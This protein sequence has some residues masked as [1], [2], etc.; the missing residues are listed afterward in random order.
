MAND[1]KEDL[2]LRDRCVAGDA[3][4]TE[5][6]VRQYSGLVY[7]SIQHAL[8][9]RQVFCS[10]ADWEDLHNTVFLQLFEHGCRRLRQYQGK[11]G[12]TLAS[13]IRLIAVRT[14]LNHLRKKSLFS[15]G[16]R[17]QLLALDEIGEMKDHRK[18]VWSQLLQ[19][20]QMAVMEKGIGALSSRD[21]LFFRLYFEKG[22]SLQETAEALQISIQNMHTIKHRAVQKLKAY[23]QEAMET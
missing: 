12:C 17:R 9:L 5:Q 16:D 10:P 7:H 2:N 4:A 20:E 6:L 21:R 3:E 13:W 8:R 14:V 1:L 11:S 18:S 23:V 19:S 15:L 22:L